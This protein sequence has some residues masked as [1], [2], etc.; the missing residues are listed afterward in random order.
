MPFASNEGV[1]IH[2]EV[3]GQGEP[4]I[5]VHGFMGNLERW[6]GAGYVDALKNN[7]RCILV[8]ARGHGDSDKP[9]DSEQYQI[10]VTVRDIVAIVDDLALNQAHYWGYSMGAVLGLGVATFGGDRFRSVVM[11][12]AAPG[13]RDAVAKQRLDAYLERLKGGME[14][15]VEG[16]PP[17]RREALMKNDPLALAAQVTATNADPVLDLASP[18]APCL[19]YNGGADPSAPR[20]K[21]MER[22]TPSSVRYEYIGDL[23]H[24]QGFQR[25]D[26]VL[27]VVRAFLSDVSKAATAK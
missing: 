22:K 1:R 6:C 21:E 10:R 12:G 15:M 8:D 9:H 2:Y 16:M 14:A 19:F 23:D 20:A 5:L 17:E 25:S 24:A 13:P 4:L 11:G 26:L 7:Y 18:V 27:P 3:E